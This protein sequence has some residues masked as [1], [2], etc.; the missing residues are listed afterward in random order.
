MDHTRSI[1]AIEIEGVTNSL[2]DARN[3]GVRTRFIT[4]VNEDKIFYCKELITFVDDVD[5][6][7]GTFYINDLEYLVPTQLHDKEKPA[8]EIIYSNVSELVEHQ[9]YIFDTL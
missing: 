6:I 4:G 1:L 3:R 8:S 9:Q 5:G 2:L 7:K